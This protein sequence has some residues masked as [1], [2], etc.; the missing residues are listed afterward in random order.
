MLL[1]FADSEVA[2]VRLVGDTLAL[3]FAAARIAGEPA[4]YLP[5]LVLTMTHAQLEAPLA[6]C[7]GRVAEGEVRVDGQRRGM[8]ELPG[9]IAAP[10]R[11]S[12]RFANGSALEAAG[13]T[14][15]AALPPGT[16]AAEHYHC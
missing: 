15:I 6:G 3:R 11:L 7:I 2:A 16:A 12:L 4:H 14:L 10:V 8:L 9:A 1:V 13:A 5:G